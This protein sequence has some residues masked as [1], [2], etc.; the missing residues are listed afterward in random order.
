MSQWM[1]SMVGYLLIVSVTMQLLPHKKYEQYVKL[2]TGFLMLILL[3]QP[4]LKIGS[5][6]VFLEKQI[7]A[8]MQEQERLEEKIGKETD[9]FQKE[10]ESQEEIEG[11][12]KTKDELGEIEIRRIDPVE[13]VIED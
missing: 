6:D 4:L 2:F 11:I 8:F 10:V 1:K 7:S 12:E 13:V 9:R 5:A 3:L